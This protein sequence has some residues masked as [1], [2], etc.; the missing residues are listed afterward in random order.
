MP[1]KKQSKTNTKKIYGSDSMTIEEIKETPK[2]ELQNV[3]RVDPS[4]Y[5]PE[6]YSQTS[7]IFNGQEYNYLD[8]DM[9]NKDFQ[10]HLGNKSSVYKINM[11]IFKINDEC[12]EPFLEYYIELNNKK[13]MFPNFELDT[14]TLDK[15]NINDAFEEQCY[16]FFQKISNTKADLTSKIYR[17]FLEE[18]VNNLYVFFDST[19][20]DLKTDDTHFWGILD[21]IANE[22]RIYDNT[23]D[24]DISNLVQ[25][26][27][28][29]AYIKDKN[30]DRI[31]MPCCL[32]LCK[33]N[34]NGEYTNVYYQENENVV[35]TKSLYEEKIDH[36]T[37]GY[38]YYFTTD[39]IHKENIENIK[40][41]SVF[42][43][44]SLYVLNI[45]KNINDIEFNSD[46][47]EEDNDDN[48]KSYKDYTCVYF[49]ED[50]I[51]MWCIKSLSRFVEL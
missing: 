43:D 12:K 6:V 33:L 31:N 2:T 30:G 46:N 38:H 47:E 1:S 23:L 24:S 3:L 8:E 5:E 17:G 22:K 19:Y 48:L 42:I 41:F 10:L 25:N 13:M 35:S 28:F 36:E 20:L 39:P 7:Y 21:E 32:Y 15:D 51:Q 49:F 44:N 11:C 27:E 45:N 4:I 16:S 40:R 14:L 9:M 34:E 18:G 37:F 29:I 26:H 50:G